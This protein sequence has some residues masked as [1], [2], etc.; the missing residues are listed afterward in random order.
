[1]RTLDDHDQRLV[2]G[3][4]VAAKLYVRAAMQDARMA[5]RIALVALDAAER[6]HVRDLEGDA[7]FGM[8]LKAE[9]LHR[10][11]AASEPE[12]KP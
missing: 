3:S 2:Y 11:S 5:L 4:A 10:A 9:E 8:L 1:V 7:P 6:R 12:A